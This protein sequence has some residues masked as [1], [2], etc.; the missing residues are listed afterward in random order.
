MSLG[1][2]LYIESVTAHHIKRN[3]HSCF[4]NRWPKLKTGRPT[5]IMAGKHC[6]FYIVQKWVG[7]R[8]GVGLGAPMKVYIYIKLFN[9]FTIMQPLN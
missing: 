5:K 1:C 3:D 2:D 4:Q 8:V 7:F 9:F 6:M